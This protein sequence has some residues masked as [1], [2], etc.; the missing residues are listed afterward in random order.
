MD[1]MAVVSRPGSS[2]VG[3]A[4][5]NA[6]HWL[7]RSLAVLRFA[8][9]APSLVPLLTAPAAFRSYPAA[10]CVFILAMDRTRF[11]GHGD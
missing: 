1:E 3:P 8:Q 11:G 9:L 10:L 5:K 4:E 6:T 2:E 7:V